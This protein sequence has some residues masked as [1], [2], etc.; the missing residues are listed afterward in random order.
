MIMLIQ[1]LSN[2][3]T[4]A[5]FHD[6]LISALIIFSFVVFVFL[7]HIYGFINISC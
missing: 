7:M 5:F 2:W 1:Y 6:Y 4:Y 3:L